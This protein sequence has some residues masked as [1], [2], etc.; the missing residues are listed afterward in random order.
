M[1]SSAGSAVPSASDAPTSAP[2][3]TSVRLGDAPTGGTPLSVSSDGT[4]SVDKSKVSGLS[5]DGSKPMW[6]TQVEAPR[7]IVGVSLPASREVWVVSDGATVAALD[8]TTVLWSSKLPDGV[9]AL[10]GLGSDTPPRWQTSKG[11]IVMAHPDSLRALDPVEGTMI[12]QVTTPVT[13][14]AAGDGY[15][16]VFNGSTTSVLA[17][18][19]GSSSTHATAL[20]TSAP[21]SADIPDPKE[22]ENASLDVPGI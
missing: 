9:G 17:F 15:V 18:D 16:V 3:T 14:W 5:L 8:G 20:P 10:N 6:A 19:S 21:A 4:V 22:L 13:S 7:K 11:A 1:P 12:W 2:S